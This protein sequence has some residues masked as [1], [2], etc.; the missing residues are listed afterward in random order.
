[1][2]R[3]ARRATLEDARVV[4][5]RGDAAE[6]RVDRC[7]QPRDVCFHRD[8]G[9]HG[10]RGAAAAGDRGDDRVGG[11]ALAAVVDAHRVAALAGEPRGGGTDAAAAAGD[12]QNARHRGPS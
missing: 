10:D 9:L 3:A 1:V 8:V 2:R 5:E 11:R 6:L 7:E 4:G 12:N